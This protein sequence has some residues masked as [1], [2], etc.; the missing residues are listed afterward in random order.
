[1]TGL[2]NTKSSEIGYVFFM[3]LVAYLGHEIFHPVAVYFPPNQILAEEVLSS[4]IK[5]TSEKSGA[6]LS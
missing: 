1:M 6:P 3:I 2:L 5:E 4:Q